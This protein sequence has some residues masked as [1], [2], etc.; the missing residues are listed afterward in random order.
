DRILHRAVGAEPSQLARFAVE[1]RA[2]PE[3]AVD[4]RDAGDESIAGEGL[5][6]LAGLRVDLVDLRVLELADVEVAVGPG[7][8]AVAAFSRGG[9]RAHHATVGRAHHEDL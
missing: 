2:V 7:H 4:A 5:H 9:E 8:A 3:G 1:S 6:D